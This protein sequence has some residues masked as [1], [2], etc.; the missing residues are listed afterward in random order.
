MQHNNMTTLSS[1]LEKLRTKKWD[2]E[3]KWENGKFTASGSEFSPEDLQI[4]KVYR[5]E[6]ESDPGDSSVLYLIEANNGLIGYTIDAYGIYSNKD[7]EQGYDNF[8]RMVPLEDREE[9]LL[10]DM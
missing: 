9:Q 5:F 2:N 10:F 6:G 4:I 1:V 3:F 7:D 8:L